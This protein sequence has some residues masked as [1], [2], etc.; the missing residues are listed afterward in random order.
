MPIIRHLPEHLVNQIAAGEVVERPASVVK[1]LVENALDAQATSILIDL[2]D[3]GKSF[4]SVRDNG[5]GMDATDLQNCIQRHATSKLSDDNLFAISH[6]GFRGEALPSIASVSSMEITSRTAD[7]EH[8]LKISIENGISTN[9]LPT[10][11]DIG[12][13]VTVRNLFHLIPARLKFLKGTNTEYAVTKDILYRLAMAHPTVSFR[14]THNGVVIFNYQTPP[15]LGQQAQDQR[16]RDVMGDD[17]VENSLPLS[18]MRENYHLY[19]RIG[20]PTYSSGTAQDQ[21]LFVNQRPVKDRSLLGALRAAYNDV[22]P[23]DR[24]P[25]AVL[26]LTLP[27]DQVDVNVHPAKTEVRFQDQ[28]AIRGLIVSSILHCLKSNALPVNQN[29]NTALFEKFTPSAPQNF[30]NS[31]NSLNPNGG[32]ATYFYEPDNNYQHRT[33]N[34]PTAQSYQINDNGESEKQLW[35]LGAARAQIHENYIISQTSDGIV[36]VDQH[37]AHE[38]LVYEAFKAQIYKGKIESQSF[39]TPEIINLDEAECKLILEKQEFFVQCGFHI[40]S[41]GADAIAVNSLPLLLVGRCDL[42]KLFQDILSALHEQK[43]ITHVEDKMNEVLSRMACHGSVRS[44]RRLS[45]EEMNALLRQMESTPLA[46]QCNHGRPT[47]ITLSLKE[48]EKLFGRR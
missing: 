19:G 2:R 21:F 26:F 31:P 20:L 41:F 25:S 13:S 34:M 7:S 22:M 4:I 46:A 10:A 23:R 12:T 40:S 18:A 9:L 11:G 45:I 16:M 8:A 32:A 28:A 15:L 17:F 48:I 1:E 3:G 42:A 39:L 38:R 43:P 47:F 36:I 14:L 24:Y 44:G 27:P 6:L 30:L 35:P 29:L 5:K 33:L 37:A